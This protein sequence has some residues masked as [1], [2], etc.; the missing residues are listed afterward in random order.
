MAFADSMMG[1]SSGALSTFIIGV[2][3]LVVVGIIGAIYY[4]KWKSNLYSAYK[5]VVWER[6]GFGQ[7][8]MLFDDA[9]I[10]I[11]RKSNNKRFFMRKAN[12]GLEPDNIPYLPGSDGKKYVFLLRTGLK[13]F[14]FIRP[15]IG[16]TGVVVL[17]VGEEDVNWAINSYERQKKVFQSNTLLAYMPFI[18]LAFVSLVIL[19]I[20]IYFFRNFDTLSQ[21]AQ[22]M[23]H[24][25]TVLAQAQ[26]GTV[27]IPAG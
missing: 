26:T 19:V 16:P 4:L 11:D 27:V 20:F 14:T 6:D 22:S 3:V 8:R 24:A 23:D 17:K 12:V 18:A 1:I 2:I 15:N 21:M 7:L 10:F 5:C 13:N 25:A 9:G